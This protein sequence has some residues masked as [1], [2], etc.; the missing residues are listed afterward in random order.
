MVVMFALRG[1]VIINDPS[2]VW[3]MAIPVILFFFLLFN[4]VYF[5]TRRLGYNYDDSS[6]M[7]FHCTG[8]NFELA[9]AIA[10]TAFAS[11]PMVAVSTVVGPLI[12]IPVMLTLV[13]LALRRRR[14]IKNAIQPPKTRTDASN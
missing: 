10:L 5:T 3:Q 8:R 2:I 4:L 12:E 7:A 13:T 6:T 1:G 9:I 14:D 11:M